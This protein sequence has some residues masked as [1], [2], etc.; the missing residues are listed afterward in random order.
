MLDADGYLWYR[1][2]MEDVPRTATVEVAKTALQDLIGKG[3]AGPTTGGTVQ[4]GTR[5]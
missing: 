5:R 3:E 2:R 4:K 1:G